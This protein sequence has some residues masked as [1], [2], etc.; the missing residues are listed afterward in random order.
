MTSLSA[1]LPTVPQSPTVKATAP[2]QP[3]PDMGAR[4]GSV[5]ESDDGVM[6]V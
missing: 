4:E 2:N 6:M 1:R 5:P 3:M